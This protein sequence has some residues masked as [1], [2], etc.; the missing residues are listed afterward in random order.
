MNDN[1][2]LLS[3]IQPSGDIHIGNLLGAI[4][5]WIKL[6]DDYNSF[7]TIVDY[8]AITVNYPILQFK[9]RIIDSAIVNIACGIN[10][11]K[12]TIFIQKTHLDL[13]LAF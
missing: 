5:N 13:S 1:K 4:R 6:L 8:H 10:P 7:F 9:E 2:I 11:D 3:G 12:A